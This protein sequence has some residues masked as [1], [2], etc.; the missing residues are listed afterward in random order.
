MVMPETAS[1]KFL[2]VALR[3]Q[4]LNVTLPN[5]EL[6]VFSQIDGPETER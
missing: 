4:A 6:A 5:I 1:T 3:D 2:E